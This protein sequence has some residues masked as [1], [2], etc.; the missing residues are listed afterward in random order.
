MSSSAAKSQTKQTAGKK[1]PRYNYDPLKES[2]KRYAIMF[3]LQT[4]EDSEDFTVS[5]NPPSLKS[6][7]V[8]VSA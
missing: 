2:V 4:V 3:P 6:R 5:G 8:S 7:A 1:Q